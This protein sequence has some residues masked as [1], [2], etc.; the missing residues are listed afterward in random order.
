MLLVKVEYSTLVVFYSTLR[1]WWA[2]WVPH[3]DMGLPSSS[4]ELEP[5]P[6]AWAPSLATMFLSS[7][8]FV[9]RL[10]NI[11]PG[12]ALL[13]WLL[14]L[15]LRPSPLSGQKPEDKYPVVPTNYGKLRGIKKGLNNEIL[16]PVVQYLGIPYATPPIG[17]RRFQPPE[18]PASW[19]EVRNAT[20]FAPVC[21][22][23]I[24][25]M[26]PAIMLPVWFTDNL[27]IVASYVQNQS[28]DCLYLNVY[29][30]MED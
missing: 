26:L 7:P 18:A 1:A 8:S 23:N 10:L 19:S 11:R 5:G 17:E 15:A 2:S 4:W 29:V 12:S 28:E 6:P 16:G 20:A 27:E 22:Q 21:P 13:F 30:P 25:G 14:G 9:R 24:H 3:E